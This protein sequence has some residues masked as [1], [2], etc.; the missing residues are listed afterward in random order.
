MDDGTIE[1]L[2]DKYKT[3]QF[4]SI[5][6]IDMADEIRLYKILDGMTPGQVAGLPHVPVDE[7]PWL[8]YIKEALK[9]NGVKT[10]AKR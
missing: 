4:Q 10:Q 2:N 5:L 3:Y 6:G 7:N 9:E 8:T 1:S